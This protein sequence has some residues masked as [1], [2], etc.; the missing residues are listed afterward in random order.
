MDGTW[1]SDGSLTLDEVRAAA[2]R[3]SR[4]WATATHSHREPAPVFRAALSP[5]ERR[6][7]SS[8]AIINRCAI[9]RAPRERFSRAF[10]GARSS[11]PARLRLRRGRNRDCNGR[12]LYECMKFRGRRSLT[13]A[14]SW[15]P[16]RSLA[17]AHSAGQALASPFSRARFRRSAPQAP[18][19]VA[20][21]TIFAARDPSRHGALSW[22]RLRWLATR[23]FACAPRRRSNSSR[24]STP[25]CAAPSR[26]W[27][28]WTH[29]DCTPQSFLERSISDARATALLIRPRRPYQRRAR[30]GPRH[31]TQH[32]RMAD[33][34]PKLKTA[35]SCSSRPF[36]RALVATNPSPAHSRRGRRPCAHDRSRHAEFALSEADYFLGVLHSEEKPSQLRWLL[37]GHASWFNTNSGERFLDSVRECAA[38][39][40]R[41]IPMSLHRLSHISSVTGSSGQ[42]S[43]CRDRHLVQHKTQGH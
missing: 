15:T 40:A 30:P 12:S 24:P 26:A 7:S 6:A 10:A 25:S 28:L 29:N 33:T 37:V 18:P 42:A 34:R 27:L 32:C 4:A 41:I 5:Q 43:S 8:S 3:I 31:R 11:R 23:A 20:S 2:R 38:N 16:F 39:I 9:A 22:A 13:N 14:I 21:F 36:G 17:H 1:F 19:V 35:P